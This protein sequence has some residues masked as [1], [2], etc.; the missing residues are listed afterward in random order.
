M[1]NLEIF[2]SAV[3]FKSFAS[4]K[5][6]PNSLPEVAFLGRSNSGKSTLINTIVG[7]KQLVKTS[8]TPGKTKLINYFG[9]QDNFYFVDLP[10]FGY[11]KVSHK[12]H[13]IMMQLLDEYLNQSQKL[14]VLLILVDC[15]REIPEEEGGYIIASLERGIQP[16]LIRTKTDKLNQSEKSKL[17]KS[18]DAW[19]KNYKG[20]EVYLTTNKIDQGMLNLKKLILSLMNR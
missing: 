9:V 20:L 11:S 4:G 17:M 15:K 7:Q 19:K 1:A 10:G 6:L 13:K 5:D 8:K 3:F 18:M 14:K 12:E 2:H 16:I